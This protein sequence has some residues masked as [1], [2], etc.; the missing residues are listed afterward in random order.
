MMDRSGRRASRVGGILRQSNTS[1]PV[2]SM[3]TGP[4]PWPKKGGWHWLLRLQTPKRG[5]GH[6][7]D[8]PEGLCADALRMRVEETCAWED[9]CKGLLLRF[10]RLQQQHYG[11]QLFAYTLINLREFCGV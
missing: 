3:A 11:M 7:H 8:R 9:T 2:C 1:T 4:T 10:E 5:E 6:R